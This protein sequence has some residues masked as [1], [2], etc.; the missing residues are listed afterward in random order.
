MVTGHGII[1]PGQAQYITLRL[2]P[3]LIIGIIN[4]YAH[5]Y[6]NSRVRLWNQIRE[7][8]L[9]EAEWLIAGDFNMIELLE[10]KRG[11]AITTGQSHTETLAWN[12]LRLQ[13][14]LHDTFYLDEFRHLTPL[15]F[16]WGNRRKGQEAIVSRL[17]RFYVTDRLKNIGGHS[18]IW[19]SA[20]HISDH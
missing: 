1:V 7:F 12:A 8:N 15:R 9:P 18:G 16:T 6:S 5:N 20:P 17:D 11:G 2:A 13:L 14:Q 10:D 4:V 19:R 3:D